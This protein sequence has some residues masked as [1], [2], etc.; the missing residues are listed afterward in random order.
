MKLF[1]K[2]KNNF[3]NNKK[4]NFTQL[5]NEIIN[6]NIIEFFDYVKNNKSAQDKLKNCE[7]QQCIEMINSKITEK[8]IKL[9]NKIAKNEN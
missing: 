7:E 2:L 1:D 8:I 4:N 5:L 3:E 6:N 9:K